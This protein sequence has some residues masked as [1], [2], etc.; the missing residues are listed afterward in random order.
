M[1]IIRYDIFLNDSLKKAKNIYI[2][3]I[4]FF[5]IIA[6]KASVYIIIIF[7]LLKKRLENYKNIKKKIYLKINKSSSE[8]FYYSKKIYNY[9]Y[10]K[11]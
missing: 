9:N 2:I 1:R 10:Y 7:N 4:I 6:A 3:I 5:I 11:N 8:E